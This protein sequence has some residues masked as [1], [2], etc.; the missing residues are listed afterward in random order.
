MDTKVNGGVG[1]KQKKIHVVC[2]SQS[3]LHISR[4][5]SF[6]SR[7]KH[8]GFQYHFVRELVEDG[9]VDLWKIHTKENLI[10]VM[11]KSINTEKFVWSRS[12]Y[13]LTE[14]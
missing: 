10:D 2:D 4:N 14:T 8:I 11:T 12:F 13:G 9:S 6:H 3:A 5:L 1:L 7:A